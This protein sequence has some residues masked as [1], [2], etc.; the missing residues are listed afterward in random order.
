R[1]SRSRKS[2][3]PFSTSRSRS[4][5]A[6]SQPGSLVPVSNQILSGSPSSSS[7]IIRRM[8]SSS[9]HTPGDMTMSRRKNVGNQSP[10]ASVSSPPIDD[11][12]SPVNS[13]SDRVRYFWSMN[14]LSSSI[15]NWPYFFAKPRL[16]FSS[17]ALS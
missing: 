9:H 13:A 16:R 12:P 10:S 6:R 14:G 5:R 15:K 4:F 17:S 7:S 11:P 1:Y 8:A 2:N 3:Q